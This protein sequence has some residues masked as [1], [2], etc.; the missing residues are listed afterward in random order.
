[1]NKE[2]KIRVVSEFSSE[3]M[4]TREWNKIFKVLREKS[5]Q[6]RIMYC[7]KLYFKSKGEIKIIREKQR[8][9]CQWIIF[10]RNVKKG[11]LGARKMLQMRNPE[12]KALQKKRMKIK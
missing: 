11:S 12:E 10:A 9:F 8:I 6:P 5:H 2:A 4:Q 7:V 3:I 1:M